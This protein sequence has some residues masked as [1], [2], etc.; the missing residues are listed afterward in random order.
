M[1]A[2]PSASD[3]VGQVTG[4]G[5]AVS[6]ARSSAFEILRRVEDDSAFASVLLA[7]PDEEIRPADRNLCYELVMGV[8]RWQSWLDA[9]ID[10]YSQRKAETL[11]PPIRRALRIGL[12]EL[13]FLSRIPHSATVNEAVNLTRLARLSSA[14]ALVNAVLRRAIRERDYDPERGIEDPVLRLSVATSHPTWLIDRWIK[15][16]GLRETQAFALSNNETPPVAFRVVPEKA[17]SEEVLDSLRDA[18]ASVS[19]S[20][21]APGGYRVEGA[22]AKVRE[23]AAAGYIY[24]QDEASQLVGHAL[25]ANV[26][27]RILDV[28]AAPGSKT[29]H[30]ASLAGGSAVIIAGDLYPHRLRTVRETMSRVGAKGIDLLVYDATAA[31][32]FPDQSFDRVLVDAP[33]SG[34]GT[35]RHN[36][37][38]KWRIT[39]QDIVAMA[40]RQGRILANAA[41]VVRAGGRVVYST[42]SVE[43][44]E[45][46]A[47]V[48]AFLQEHKYFTQ[49]AV[50]ADSLLQCVDGSL[51]TWP[52]RDGTDGFYLAVLERR[53]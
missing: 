51:R 10:R 46:E 8:L 35:L 34:T 40:E 9:L 11:D 5:R 14:S 4:K 31:L 2:R 23:L 29:T 38:I 20:S 43:T 33:C 28:C 16:F 42:C 52:H 1:T 47:V 49:G 17:E 26:G 6:P 15:A 22:S 37:E 13:R 53:K 18:G 7:A 50:K 24:L 44:D 48:N 39:D 41:K 45:N 27:E 36:P 12:Y 30:I 21:V 32:P 3:R 19:S 25:E